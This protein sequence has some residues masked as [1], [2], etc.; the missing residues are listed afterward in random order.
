MPE[1][2]W[3]AAAALARRHGVHY[4]SRELGLNHTPLKKRVSDAQR[5]RVV[6]GGGFV[7]VDLGKVMGGRPMTEVVVELQGKDGTRLTIKTVGQDLPD[8]VGLA[9]EFWSRGR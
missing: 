3:E 2:L 7:E 5:G 9:H 8:V 4:V 1:E 6:K